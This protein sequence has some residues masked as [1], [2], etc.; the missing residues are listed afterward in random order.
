M[1]RIMPAAPFEKPWGAPAGG[2][3]FVPDTPVREAQIAAIS[4]PEEHLSMGKQHICFR[5]RAIQ[6]SV[7]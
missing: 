7:A 3:G 2:R 6:E 4:V 1:A 5:A